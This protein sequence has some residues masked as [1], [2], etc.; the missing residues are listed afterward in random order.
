MVRDSQ[1]GLGSATSH[2]T[3]LKEAADGLKKE[4]ELTKRQL[5]EVITKSATLK[6][7]LPG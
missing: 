6:V 2:L 3:S 5:T 4:L 7:C 1:S